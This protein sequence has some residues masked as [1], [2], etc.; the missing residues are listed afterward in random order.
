MG[1]TDRDFAPATATIVAAPGSQ[2]AESGSPSR[3]SASKVSGRRRTSILTALSR[4]DRGSRYRI[5]VL[6]YHR[7]AE[8]VDDEL[9]PRLLSATPASFAAQI[10][11][12]ARH[13]TPLSVAELL[14]IRR[15]EAALP[16]NAVV[17]TFD[18]A[19]RDFGDV[20][21]PTLR[22][23]GVPVTMFVPTAFPDT[24]ERFWWDRVHHAVCSAGYPARFA[25]PVGETTVRSA[26]DRRLFMSRMADWVF[27]TPHDLAM[28]EIDALCTELGASAL[29]PSVLG[30]DELRRL[31]AEG[32]A[33]APH[34]RRH[35]LLNQVPLA[36]AQTEIL[37]SA[38]DLVRELGRCAP[39]FSF[40][41]GGH[42]RELLEWLATTDLEVAVTTT[43]GNNDIRVSDWHRLR[44]MNVG[45]RT[46]PTILALQFLSWFP[47]RSAWEN[48]DAMAA[49]A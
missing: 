47:Q 7:V 16:P 19:Y 33:L 38:A 8:R 17:V 48:S 49:R 26:E 31:A 15:G 41:A 29:P 24:D 37:G 9:D 14:E 28:A 44:R 46:T 36:T 10:E 22:H 6:M 35:P 34:S 42:S 25:S 5:P 1:V 3:K 30:W 39:V 27:H 20:A 4:L 45:R 11:Y 40:P 21:W 32:V 12:L 23:Y 13:R 43:R 2:T 18:D